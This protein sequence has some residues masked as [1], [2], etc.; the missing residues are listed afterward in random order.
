MENFKSTHYLGNASGASIYIGITFENDNLRISGVVRP[1]S[2]GN[3]YACGQINDYLKDI[4]KLDSNWTV[5]MITKLSEIWSEWHLN[6]L[7][8]GTEKQMKWI[9]NNSPDNRDY[10][11]LLK[12]MPPDILVD[13]GYKYG[14][15]WI[16]KEVPADVVEWLKNLPETSRQCPWRNL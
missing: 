12:I 7:N 16:H 13:D 14:S 8:S 3:C 1:T 9:D 2:Y 15:G 11:H 4:N 6:D 10:K 5:G